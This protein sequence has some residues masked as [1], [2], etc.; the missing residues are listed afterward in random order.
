M[1]ISHILGVPFNVMTVDEAMSLFISCLD[2]PYCNVV[3]TPNPEGVMLARRDKSFYDALIDADL[4]LADGTGIVLASKLT[5]APIG[6][7]LRGYD[8]VTELFSRLAA[9]G[10]ET[11]VYFLGC[12]PGIAEIAAK[13]TAE[14]YPPL[15]I[16]GFRDGYFTAEEETLIAD[17]IKTLKP[18]ILLVGMGMPRQELFAHTHRDLPVKLVFCVGGS[19]DIMAGN[20]KL[21]P[22]ALRKLGLEWLYRLITQPSRARRM[23]V[24]PKFAALA[25]WRF[26]NPFKRVEDL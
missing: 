17:E 9:L 11:S 25:L 7:R 2:K 15:K 16:A 3:V 20:V 14:K 24:L 5:R 10:R 21:A 8:T 19:L 22:A 26:L 13:N 23:L 4:C 1:T 6:N 18:D 12:A